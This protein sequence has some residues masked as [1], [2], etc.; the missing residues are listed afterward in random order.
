MQHAYG[1][2]ESAWGTKGIAGADGQSINLYAEHLKGTEGAVLSRTSNPTACSP[3]T[4]PFQY[5]GGIV[6]A[7][8]HLDGKAPELY[9][10]NLRNSGADGKGESGLTT[11]WPRN[12]PPAISIPATSRPDGRRATR[13][14]CRQ[15]SMR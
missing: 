8:R 12:W 10:S 1:T 7:V 3:P 4:I 6:R 15:S 11:P 14:G 13:H 9:I 2:D 5:L